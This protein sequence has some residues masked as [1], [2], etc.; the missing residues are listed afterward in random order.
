MSH[1]FHPDRH[2][3]TDTQAVDCDKLP[4]RRRRVGEFVA[5][6]RASHMNLGG[7]E[8]GCRHHHLGETVRRPG[9]AAAG[10]PMKRTCPGRP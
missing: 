4:V 6:P 10:P 9:R 7:L 5:A 2:A 3:A 1:G 8:I